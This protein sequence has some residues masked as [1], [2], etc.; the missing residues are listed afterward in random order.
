MKQLQSLIKTGGGTFD[1]SENNIYFI[2]LSPGSQQSFSDEELKLINTGGGT[3]DP[4]DEG[5]YFI[6][7]GPSRLIDGAPVHD[8]LLIAVNELNTEK[9][10]KHLEGWFQTG[11]RVFIDSGIFNLTNV[12]KRKHGITMDEA[13]S[14]APDEIDGFSELFDRY[15]EIVR[16]YQDQSWGYIELDQGGRDNKIKTRKI[17]EDLG[18]KPIPVYHPLND[19]WE[20]FDYLAERYD[21]IC[22][23]NV[24][25]ADRYTRKRLIA[26][27]WERHRK[28]PNLW[29]HLLGF[30]PNEW[31]N[32]L[33]VNSGDSSAWL[34]S[35]K[36]SGYKEKT[37]LASF[38]EMPKNFQ[39]VLGSDIDADH[40]SKYGARMAAYGSYINQ[41]NWQNH[42]AAMREIGFDIYP[43]VQEG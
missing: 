8:Y 36:W 6:A 32:A 20:Y 24:V 26:T 23:G 22:F 21:R 28:Y 19:G 1:P 42:L 7:A 33:P 5:V 2:A 16:K 38:G 18:L 27:A 34:S 41:T 4:K 10:L 9:E 29:I 39:Y 31:L 25:Q 15:V 11:K 37:M 3:Y 30:T 14:L 40:S 12:H 17:L 35:V 13:L 43:A